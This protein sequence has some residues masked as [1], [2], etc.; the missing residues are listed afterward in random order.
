MDET[1]HSCCGAGARSV[2]LDVAGDGGGVLRAA[3]A[4]EPASRIALVG[5]GVD[6]KPGRAES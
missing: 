5:T 2:Q 3:R 6:R 4:R 1:Q